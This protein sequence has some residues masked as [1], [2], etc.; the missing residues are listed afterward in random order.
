MPGDLWAREDVGAGPVWALSCVTET[1][2]R[3]E[4]TEGRTWV[5]P[6]QVSPTSRRRAMWAEMAAVLIEGLHIEKEKERNLPKWNNSK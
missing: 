6:A 2:R 4:V 3:M 1:Q 5:Q